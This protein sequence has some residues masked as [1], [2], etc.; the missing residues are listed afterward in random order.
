MESG[1]FYFLFLTDVLQFN[2]L[3]NVY[4][5]I[6]VISCLSSTIPCL[7]FLLISFAR[8]MKGFYQ[9]SLGNE[10]EILKSERFKKLRHSYVGERAMNR[11]ILLSSCHWKTLVLFCLGKKRPENSFST[12]TVNYRK[13][14]QKNKL[15]HSKHY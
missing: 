14:V 1:S 5:E 3:I 12:L 8:E 15:W 13:T 10:I 9:S 4:F 2:Y 6:T 7:R 11:T